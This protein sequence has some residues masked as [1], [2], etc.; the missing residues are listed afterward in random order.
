[1]EKLKHFWHRDG[2]RSVLASLLSIFIGLLAGSVL[3]LVVGLGNPTLGLKSAWDGIRLVFL[4][5]LSTGRDAATGA[6]T[7]GFNPTSVGN[8]FFIG[9]KSQI[10]QRLHIRCCGTPN[11]VAA[12]NNRLGTGV[13]GVGLQ[14]VPGQALYIQLLR[15]K[16]KESLFN[17]RFQGHSEAFLIAADG[18]FS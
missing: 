5:L 1:M 6:L 4:G 11:L 8:L 15:F 14:A 9:N 16:I 18:A 2:T 17:N 10:V 13:F 7:F 3:I 12:A